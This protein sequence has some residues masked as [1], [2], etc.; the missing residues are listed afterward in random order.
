MLPCGKCPACRQRIKN[1]W[2]TRMTLETKSSITSWFCTL[3]YADEHVPR[4][5]NYSVVNKKDIQKFIK[6]LRKAEN[7]S[8]QK[9][10]M[11]NQ[12]LRYVCY[13]EYGSKTNRPHYHLII[14]N[15][16]KHS[17]DRLTT[18]WGKG[19]ADVQSPQNAN[20]CQEYAA[21]YLT[22]IEDFRHYKVPPFK[23]QSINLGLDF[24]QKNRGKLK[25]GLIQ[26]DGFQIPMPK[27][28]RKKFYTESEWFTIRQASEIQLELE[29][30]QA[31]EELLALN[32]NDHRQQWEM[33]DQ[34]RE[35]RN[36]SITL[37]SYRSDKF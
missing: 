15:A 12:K 13:A 18:I 22:K 7:K 30:K 36:K 31:M 32:E 16:T 28:W 5:G 19:Y 27:N 1:E 34:Q 35:I 9:P 4:L 8:Y 21:K 6:R 14:W 26:M 23:L 3:T 33:I 17:M 10:L 20:A 2:T 25:N 29:Q 24:L 11:Q 37:K